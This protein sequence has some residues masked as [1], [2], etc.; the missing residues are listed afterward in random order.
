M[1]TGI[2]VAI[3]I[4]AACASLLAAGAGLPGT[5]LAQD[6]AVTTRQFT[7]AGGPPERVVKLEN[8]L[9]K[10]IYKAQS[11]YGPP[12]IRYIVVRDGQVLWGCQGQNT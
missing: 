6:Q 4:I 2:K 9:E 11:R 8:G 12:G 3:I 10:W 7:G 5:S 1:T